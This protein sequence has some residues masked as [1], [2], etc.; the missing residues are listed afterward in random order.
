MG[1]GSKHCVHCSAV[2]VG[3]G[4]AHLNMA[5][6][7]IPHASSNAVLLVGMRRPQDW[8]VHLIVWQVC[9]DLPCCGICTLAIQ[10]SELWPLFSCCQAM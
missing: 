8:R 9:H 7:V 1:H 10:T 5:C 2:P 4:C 3:S 6:A